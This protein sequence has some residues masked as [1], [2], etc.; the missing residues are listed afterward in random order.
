MLLVDAPR[1]TSRGEGIPAEA[2]AW[3]DALLRELPPARAARIV[4]ERTGASRDA[5][6]A[7]ALERRKDGPR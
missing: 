7:R 1:E 5:L 3:L 6:Y 4:A 2:A